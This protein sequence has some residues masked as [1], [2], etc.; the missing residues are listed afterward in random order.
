MNE[1]RNTNTI[2]R[3]ITGKRIQHPL[4]LSAPFYWGACERVKIWSTVNIDGKEDGYILESQ[5]YDG[6]TPETHPEMRGWIGVNEFNNCF[7]SEE[8]I[9]N[10][11]MYK[12]TIAG[13]LEDDGM[14][15][16]LGEYWREKMM[17]LLY[18]NEIA[19]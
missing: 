1:E 14:S 11:P 12:A 17:D 7:A 8:E 3:N 5:D 6:C 9:A 10:I 15:S 2:Y 19:D 13:L 18:D 4:R 16:E